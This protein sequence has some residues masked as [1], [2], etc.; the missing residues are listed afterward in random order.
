MHNAPYDLD[1]DSGGDRFPVSGPAPR[2]SWKP[3]SDADGSV[4]YELD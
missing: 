4:E 1:I 3:P 2:L